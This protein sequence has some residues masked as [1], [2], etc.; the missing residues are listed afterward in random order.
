M[1]STIDKWPSFMA[2]GNFGLIPILSPNT[3]YHNG[4]LSSLKKKI[5][6]KDRNILNLHTKCLGLCVSSVTVS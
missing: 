5:G 1:F 4:E 3:D 6:K 2:C